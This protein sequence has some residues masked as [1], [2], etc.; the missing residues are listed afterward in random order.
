MNRQP[1]RRELTTGRSDCAGSSTTRF[2][3][4]PLAILGLGAF[5]IAVLLGADGDKASQDDLQ[6]WGEFVAA[7]K[8]DV[9]ASERI[10]PYYEEL[11]EPILGFLKEM[12]AKAEWA[13]WDNKPEIHRLGEHVHFLIPLTFDGR[14]GNYCF[15]FL[16]AGGV[17]FFRHMEAI[18]IRLDKTGPLP[19]SI[20]PDVDEETKAHIREE[21]RWSREIRLFNI[22]AE[23]KGKDFAFDFFKDGNGY[24]LAAK[25]WV[26]FVEPK[27]AFILYVCWEQS[28]L[29]GNEVT[30]EKLEDGEAL[31]RL[32]TYY[33][34]LY[35]ATAHLRQW[36]SFADYTKI[37][38]TI[39][40]DRARAAGWSL[41]IEYGNEGY[42]ARECVLRFKKRF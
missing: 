9:I 22:L 13:E 26:P 38:E 33:F 41:E 10:R 19:T 1:L 20:F 17:W 7:M 37:F 11:R 34:A 28:N 6:I 32:S 16:E 40:Q 5:L 23:V 42:P 36:I 8:K 2:I 31:I 15:T 12:R 39:W 14:T 35:K 21:T 4:S 25:T 27:R 18:N 24:F 30:L 3:A 29:R